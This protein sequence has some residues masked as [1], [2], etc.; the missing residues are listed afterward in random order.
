MSPTPRG[1]K[2][3]PTDNKQIKVSK[4]TSAHVPQSQM[5][6]CVIHKKH[7]RLMISG[8]VYTTQ[9]ETVCLLKLSGKGY[10][11]ETEAG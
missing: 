2:K 9:I 1:K 10:F 3:I 4:W 6:K 7:S 11:H 8:W 5:H